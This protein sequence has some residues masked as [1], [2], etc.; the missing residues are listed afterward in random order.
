MN[1]VEY[2]IW[3]A[4]FIDGE[5]CFF[6]TPSRSANCHTP[7]LAISQTRP[8]PLDVLAEVL[9]GTVRLRKAPTAAGSPVYTLTY[10]GA[11]SVAAA[12][13]KLLPYLILKKREAEL[14][15]AYCDTVGYNRNGVPR[16]VHARRHALA[17]RLKEAR[18]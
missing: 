1:E 4:G 18:R 5:G 15:R 3:A 7:G 12:I 9:G 8:E 11:K 6:L 17:R 13:D 14:V 2:T 16:L 10:T